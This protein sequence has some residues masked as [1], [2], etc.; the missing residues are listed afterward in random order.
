MDD[1]FESPAF[2]EMAREHQDDLASRLDGSRVLNAVFKF[3]GRFV[4]YP[5]EAAQ[6]AHTLWIAHAHLMD[7][8]ESTPRIAF[9]SPEAASGKTRCLELTELLVPNPVEAV[10]V[11]PAYLFRKIGD[12]AGRPTIL[13][14]EIDTVFGPK[15]REN[16][17]VRGLLN[18]GHRRGAVAGRCTVKGKKI[19]TEELPAYCAVALAGLGQ[20]PDT[21]FSRSVIVRMRR[22]APDETVEPFRRRLHAPEGKAICD[23]LVSW[24]TSI[25][26]TIARYIPSMP[27]GIADRDAD[28]WEPLLA[29]ADLA[30]GDWPERARRF[31]VSLVSASK[32]G[33]GSL[34]V[35]L[36]SDILEIF[37][38]ASTT[39]KSYPKLYNE[40]N[41]KIS[42][43]VL[44]NKLC[45]QLE[46][47]WAD[48]K[49]K[50]ITDQ[51]LASMLRGYG[52]TSKQVRIDDFNGKGYESEDF[53]DAWKRYLPG[54]PP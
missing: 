49:G 52:I 7:C 9:L 43:K 19:I 23:R 44:I 3:L 31:A 21:I 4:Q 25:S 1:P 15:A 38:S 20:I 13:Y 22:R 11:S 54:L 14:D 33:K 51:K 24:T 37:I 5:D 41:E 29:V 16:E 40:I 10:N 30:G 6:V 12:E 36:L 2:A 27:K 18:A 17:E 50:P 8:W 53:Y 45:A 32:E 28:V 35:Q 48:I 34:G 26:E 42:T 47:P 39:T 46:S